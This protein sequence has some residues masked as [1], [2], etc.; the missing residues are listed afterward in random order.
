MKMSTG[1]GFKHSQQTKEI[2]SIKHR[3]KNNGNWKGDN[4]GYTAL[5]NWIERNKLKPKECEHCKKLKKLEAANI[6]G[7]YKRDVNDFEWLCRNCHMLKD[8]RMEIL[9]R[10]NKSKI[11]KKFFCITCGIQKSRTGLRCKICA[12]KI[13]MTEEMRK[14]ISN[15]LKARGNIKKEMLVK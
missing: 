15:T 8:G 3:G 10:A 2:L 14:R 1:I 11:A 12:A 7:K 6:S 5:H 4:V 9:I 13:R